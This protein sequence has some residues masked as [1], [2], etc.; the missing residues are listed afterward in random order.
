MP[1]A[2]VSFGLLFIFVKNLEINLSQGTR[3]SREKQHGFS[4]SGCQG[5]TP[6]QKVSRLVEALDC[7]AV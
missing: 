4:E 2:L 1:S 5:E 6:K 3:I 7:I